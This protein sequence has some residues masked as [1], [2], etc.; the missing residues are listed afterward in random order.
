MQLFLLNTRAQFPGLFIWN[1]AEELTS[2]RE[3]EQAREQGLLERA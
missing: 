3:R 2:L 1:D